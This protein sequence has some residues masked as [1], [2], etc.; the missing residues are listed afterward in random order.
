LLL[1]SAAT[2]NISVQYWRERERERERERMENNA[3]LALHFTAH[4]N[5]AWMI[6]K[7]FSRTSKL[8]NIDTIECGSFKDLPSTKE[9]SIRVKGQY[10]LFRLD[11]A[12][13]THRNDEENGH[14]ISSTVGQNKIRVTSTSLSY[15]DPKD[16]LFR[17]LIEVNG[18]Q[19]MPKTILIPTDCD[20]NV[21]SLTFPSMSALLKAPLGSG[22]FGLYFVYNKFDIEELM[23]HHH[24]RA[25]REEKTM[26]SVMSSFESYA[27]N[28]LC[29]SL[30]EIINPIRCTLPAPL[31]GQYDDISLEAICYKRRSQIRAYV[32]ECEGELYLYE[33]LEV[34]FP[35]WNIDLDQTLI[36]EAELYSNLTNENHIFPREQI[37][38]DEVENEC[39]GKGHGR[40]YN[41]QRNKK[42]TDRFLVREIQE[43]R[44]CQDVV[45]DCVINGF[46]RLKSRILDY[47]RRHNDA[48]ITEC[49][50]LAIMGVDLL[51][52]RNKETGK[53]EAYM[54]EANNNPAMPAD[55]KRMSAMYHDHLVE[56]G[57]ALIGLSLK[58]L[59]LKNNTNSC[60]IDDAQLEKFVKNF[61]PIPMH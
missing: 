58:H 43:L 11:I 59:K 27:T 60:I 25:K 37:W 3:D 17:E 29:W 34:R 46:S 38:S 23:K 56:F 33:H 26:K 39:C 6:R 44:P 12:T 48:G 40:P 1:P 54:V 57:V 19:Y 50:T 14:S 32:V 4:H 49:T 28:P 20:I 53:Y 8:L 15:M 21:L 42:Y 36:Q 16:I 31:P 41:E 61:T 2:P 55:G 47:R 18:E 51:V 13:N 22:G 9:S 5:W 30:Q 7:A 52:S 10:S 24:E 35:L 45:K